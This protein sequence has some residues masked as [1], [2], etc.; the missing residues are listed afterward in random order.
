MAMP[1]MSHAES[2][3]CRSAPWRSFTRRVVVPWALQGQTLAGDALEI[4]GGSGA[5][6]EQLL[7]LH[8][9]LGLTVTDFDPAMVR[10][11]AERLARFGDRAMAAQADATR[12]PFAS[13]SF[14]HVL[15]FI[16]LHHVIDWEAALRE[17]V[18]VLKPR[19]TLIGYDLLSTAPAR[20]LHLA[21]GSTHRLMRFD[22]LR[23]LTAQL[24]VGHTILTR[25]LG[26]LVARFIL[27][28]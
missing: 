19:G 18:R 9:Q 11:A 22:E 12:L 16:M 25:G 17:A 3:F 7:D 14:D 28:R 23:A 20:A 6:A 27:R 13:E 15:A 24:P 2:A 1:T 8:P 21:D 4:G 26:G 5:M 10:V